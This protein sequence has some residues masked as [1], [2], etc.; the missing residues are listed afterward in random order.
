[1]SEFPHGSWFDFIELEERGIER[2]ANGW[3]GW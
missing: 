3:Y 2:I 1:M